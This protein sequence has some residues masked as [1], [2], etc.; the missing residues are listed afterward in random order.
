MN[1]KINPFFF[2]R[3]PKS[4]GVV[5]SNQLGSWK[6][7]PD[8]NSVENL[9]SGAELTE[10]A[11]DLAT[12]GFVAYEKAVGGE[13]YA[14]A[15]ESFLTRKY[16]NA[17]GPPSLIMVVPT[18]RC[19]HRCSYC[20]VSRANI[21]AAEKDITLNPAD[22]AAFIDQVAAPLF[23]LEFQGGEPLLRLGWIA[24]LTRELRKRRGKSFQV[25]IC[26]ALGP[27]ISSEF[28]DWCLEND[29]QVSTSFDGFTDVHS[30]IRLHPTN[31]QTGVTILEK[32][33][34]LRD[35]GLP[36]SLVS[37]LTK[38]TIERGAVDYVKAC[39]D[40]GVQRIYSRPLSEYG[41]AA[42]TKS[43]LGY[44]TQQYLEFFNN[45][46]DEQIA[47]YGSNHP[48]SDDSISGLL[49]RIYRP[50]SSNDV[51]SMSPAGYALSTCVIN[52]D[53]L[54]FGSDEARMLFESTKAPSLPIG[55]LLESE[56]RPGGFNLHQQLLESSFIETNVHCETC[57]Y[58]PFCGLDPVETM[59][60]Q[61]GLIGEKPTLSQCQIS[62]GTYD[63]IFERIK[64]G[65]LTEEMVK[66]WI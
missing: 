26:T 48:F 58:Q 13:I 22:T 50:Q 25:V 11:A 1:A 57:A 45:L 30:S 51:D 39:V 60:E 10:D 32:I 8:V 7:L 15:A 33:Q 40:A 35:A 63:A 27:D 42:T 38:K 49:E 47:R 18:L 43:T 3:L 36:V 66:A 20:Q 5:I 62:L 46:L 28:I 14:R 6:L 16:R 53:G 19:D 54:I 37:T 4:D 29:A 31:A 2:R 59:R 52:Y 64:R 41:Y 61:H 44:S 24:S 56:W 34:S 9:I 55:K 17:L 65:V 23:K 12:S 21:N